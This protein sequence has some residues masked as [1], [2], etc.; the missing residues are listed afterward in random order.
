MSGLEGKTKDDGQKIDEDELK[1]V[2]AVFQGFLQSLKTLHLYKADHPILLKF[3]DRLKQD[4]DSYFEKYD[5]L[6]IQ[7][8]ELHFFFDG[9]V[10]YEGREL[11]ESLAF[12]F[13]KDGIREIRFFKGLGLNEIL[14]FLTVVRKSNIVDRMVDDLVTL[15]WKK[16]FSH[17][18]FKVI[19]EFF[20]GDGIFIPN[21][22]EDLI[23]GLE[24]RGFEEV[25]TE[26]DDT[27]PGIGNGVGSEAVIGN[28][29]G[30]GVGHGKGI[31][32]GIGTGNETGAGMGSGNGTGAKGGLRRETGSGVG[33]EIGLGKGV[34]AELR[35]GAGMG[36]LTPLVVESLKQEL[37]LLTEKSLAQVCK[38]TPDE[39]EDIYRRAHKEEQLE[40][41]YALMNNFTEI[42]LH[43]GEDTKTYENIVSYFDRIVKSLLEEGEVKKV[44]TILRNFRDAMVTVPLKEKQS[45]AIERILQIAS[46]SRSIELLG[47]VMQRNN[48]ADW[49]PI[50]Q[51]L[52]LVTQNAIDPLCF[53]LGGLDAER[54]RKAV[55]EL[56]VQFCKEEIKPL[57]KFLSDSGIS[58]ISDLLYIFGKVKHPSTLK[59]LTN[60]AYH[61]NTKIREEV[62]RLATVFEEKGK[63]LV[64]KFLWDPL[65]E[66][67][68]KA[69][70]I[71]ARI[72]KDQ[73]VKALV[74]I[75]LSEDFYTRS[76]DEKVSFFKALGETKSQ[77]AIP[78]LE[79]IINKKSWF[80]NRQL[81]EM[82]TCA[83]NT[84][85]MIGAGKE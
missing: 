53:L 81:E 21:T 24:Y 85:K 59:Y 41:L 30:F 45:H 40:T 15:L 80:K 11:R 70:L 66:I 55:R 61:E 33:D 28:G 64:Q 4:F 3:Q 18:E 62:L 12:L 48:E 67:R 54:W 77:K 56:L 44:A 75:I 79:Q 60:L 34:G 68:G 17:I 51:Y 83:E 20:E 2:Q 16:D 39:V 73:A 25:G 8:D 50:T 22:D 46:D 5:D 43:L 13:Y 7:L 63:G 57:V 29:I 14:D 69:A 26:K 71:F 52:Q 82:R 1:L 35:S 6:T 74:E 76:Y 58:F 42:L 84:L 78:I 72:A 65:P 9:K 36:D 19:D 38:L 37:N 23:K 10:V 49:E 32:A 27:G 31:E 47:K